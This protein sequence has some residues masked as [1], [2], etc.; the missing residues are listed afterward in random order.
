[1]ANEVIIEEYASAGCHFPDNSFAPIPGK[2]VT[3]QVLSIASA[4]AQ[5]A[6]TTAFI[7]LQS[8]GTGFWYILGGSAP[9][10]T[11]NTNGNRW[12]PA[13]QSVDVFV[14]VGTDLKLDTA[15]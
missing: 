12:L 6:D 11:A 13:D 5:F 9:D 4:S 8:K 3:S 10:A 14:T 15:A 1:M 2:L 7:R